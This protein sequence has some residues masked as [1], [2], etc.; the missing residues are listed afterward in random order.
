MATNK[1][2][3]TIKDGEKVSRD[4]KV[5]AENKVQATYGLLA[6]SKGSGTV[7]VVD[8]AIFDFSDVSHEELLL[9]ATARCIIAF[10][11]RMKS[12][13]NGKSADRFD[14]RHYVS[15][16]VK[17]DIVDVERATTAKP[18]VERAAALVAKMSPAEKA[19]FL[20]MLS[21]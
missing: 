18:P 11:S 20:K 7:Y 19:A 15:I 3:R 12:V 5:V 10:Q 2:I 9:L 14:L 8:D 21:A 17:K 6:G 4:R 1:Q 13:I 16:N